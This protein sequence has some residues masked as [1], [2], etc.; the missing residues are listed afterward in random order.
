MLGKEIDLI[1]ANT[2]GKEKAELQKFKHE[3]RTYINEG[4]EPPVIW[5]WLPGINSG[6]FYKDIITIMIAK[7]N[8]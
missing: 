3:Y 4:N 5:T 6:N 2:K 7:N 1:I 8:N